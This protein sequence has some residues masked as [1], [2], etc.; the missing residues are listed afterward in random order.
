M[1]I[2]NVLTAHQAVMEAAV[3][4]VPDAKYGEVV[5]AWVV[6]QPRAELTRQELRKFVNTNMNPQ[7]SRYAMIHKNFHKTIP[8]RSLLGMVCWRRRCSRRI[9]QDSEW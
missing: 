7:V 4:A 6:R 8:E 5:G 2:E 1:Q 3:V 9:T